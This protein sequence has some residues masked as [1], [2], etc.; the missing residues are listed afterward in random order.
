M[1]APKKSIKECCE[2][3]NLKI[4]DL[5]NDGEIK[6][7]YHKLAIKWHPDKN[8]GNDRQRCEAKFKDIVEAYDILTDPQKRSQA[9]Y[10]SKKKEIFSRGV[11]SIARTTK[12]DG[13]LFGGGAKF[14]KQGTNPGLIHISHK[15]RQSSQ[16]SVSGLRKSKESDL[17]V[18]ENYI[19]LSEKLINGINTIYE[20]VSNAVNGSEVSVSTAASKI[21]EFKNTILKNTINSK[22]SNSFDGELESTQQ[23]GDIFKPASEN[24]QEL[25]RRNKT[26]HDEDLAS[27]NPPSDS[28]NSD[29]EKT[30]YLLSKS[31]NTPDYRMN[32]LS[33]PNYRTPNYIQQ[34]TLCSGSDGPHMFG[35]SVTNNS[36][37]CRPR[38]NL[39]KEDTFEKVPVRHAHKKI[40]EKI[41]IYPEG[42]HETKKPSEY[43]FTG[44]KLMN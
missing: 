16:G 20:T 22:T 44:G 18:K 9:E 40:I 32:M 14:A 5:N 1:N 21:L 39:F 6:K 12:F 38:V 29:T 30:P 31:Q 25:I 34:Q 41:K 28:T 36:D 27:T 42:S 4:S 24:I 37:K 43:R 2:I 7:A 26:S 10:D 8:M 19:Q 3:L 33:A 23:N 17:R 13:S 11:V 15:D 35:T